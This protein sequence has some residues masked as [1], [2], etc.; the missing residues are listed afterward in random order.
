MAAGEFHAVAAAANEALGIAE[1]AWSDVAG[2]GVA[3]AGLVDCSAGVVLDS[4]NLGW[5]N[6]PLR[7]ELHRRLEVPVLIEND[8]CASA[9]AEFAS[10]PGGT[11]PPWLYVSVGTGVGAC[12]VL[13]PVE[14]RLLCLDVGH[15]PIPGGSRRCRCGKYGCLETIASGASFTEAA[16]ACIAADPANTLNSRLATITGRDIL[17][18]AAEGDRTCIEAVTAAGRACGLA[19]ANLVNLLT[20]GGVGLAGGMVAPGS[21]YLLALVDVALSEVKPWLKDRF[22]FHIARLGERAGVIGAVELA[23]RRLVDPPASGIIST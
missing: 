9:L 21:P 19:V 15:I 13:D 2:M 17:D 18:A 5:R 7:A 3:V 11:A 22:P 12:L 4:V 14:G 8:V 6:L 20:P 10:L 1:L 23:R 16:K